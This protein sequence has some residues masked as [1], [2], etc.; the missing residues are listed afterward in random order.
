[1]TSS[2]TVPRVVQPGEP[3]NLVPRWDR[4]AQAYR[5]LG[6]IPLDEYMKG[7]LETN[8][9]KATIE[10]FMPVHDEVTFIIGPESYRQL[11]A[12]TWMCVRAALEL[13]EDRNV[14]IVVP[15]ES[16]VQAFLRRATFLADNV[17]RRSGILMASGDRIR[18]TS[19]ILSVV[20]EGA[21]ELKTTNAVLFSDR[22]WKERVIRRV[23]RNPFRMLRE[24]RRDTDGVIR[25]YAEEDEFLLEL[26]EE[27]W[28]ELSWAPGIR[29][30]GLGA[31]IPVPRSAVALGEGIVYPPGST[32]EKSI[33]A[34]T[35][36]LIDA[37]ETPD[38]EEADRLFSVLAVSQAMVHQHP[39][40]ANAERYLASLPPLRGALSATSLTGVTKSKD[41]FEPD[42]KPVKPSPVR[43]PTRLG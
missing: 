29:T 31:T 36:M 37:I 5:T 8:L 10:P 16:Q 18:Y 39:L 13:E 6:L 24:I 32:K 41:W 30:K 9:L 34:A 11:G 40:D 27:S 38:D 17:L 25:G 28:V 23:S 26:D 20:P 21:N 4:V 35:Q 33:Q 12:T 42:L 1:M 19:S 2:S 3:D 15:Q 7:A 14:T 22:A 43:R